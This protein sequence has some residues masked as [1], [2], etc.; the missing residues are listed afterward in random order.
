MQTTSGI[1]PV[2]TARIAAEWADDGP[3]IVFLRAAVADRRMW[4]HQLAALA[5]NYHV[6]AFDR[7]GF[8]EMPAV[9]EAYSQTADLFAVIDHL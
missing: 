6:I 5:P 7:R 2:G 1:V 9:N 3:P 8:G 4:R